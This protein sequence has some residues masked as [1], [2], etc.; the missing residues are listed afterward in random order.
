MVTIHK[1]VLQGS[2]EWLALR[3]GRPTASEFDSLL[4]P[5][6]AVKTG[7]AVQTFINKKVA[8][9]LLGVRPGFSSWETEQ[10]Q[11]LEDEARRRIVF[12][13]D[14]QVRNVGFVVGEDGRCG[15]SP[16]GLI[17]DDSGLEIKCPAAHTHIAYLRAGVLPSEYAPQVHGSLYVTGRKEWRFFSYH[18][19]LPA[20]SLVVKRDEAIMENIGK[21]L[22]GFYQQFDAALVHVQALKAA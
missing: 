11:I 15:C 2:P 13:Y 17:G 4:T 3:L 5:K 14:L 6:L 16:D 7:D 8:E 12:E 9:K 1:D 20:L 19:G 21:A 18:R 10:G 22:A